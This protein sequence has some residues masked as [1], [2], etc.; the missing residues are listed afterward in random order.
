MP[1]RPEE[2]VHLVG[3]IPDARAQ[4]PA[5]HPADVAGRPGEGLLQAD[6]H[7]VP[8]LVVDR[9]RR[10]SFRRAGSGLLRGGL[11][12]SGG[13]LLCSSNGLLR[14]LRGPPD[15][16]P[17]AHPS[18]HLVDRFGILPVVLDGLCVSPAVD[19]PQQLRRHIVGVA[20]AI[21][22]VNE[23]DVVRVVAGTLAHDT[24]GCPH[25]RDVLG[26]SAAGDVDVAEVASLQDGDRRRAP[27]SGCNGL[28]GRRG[29]GNSGNSLC[30]GPRMEPGDLS[31]GRGVS[32]I[33]A[34]D[35]D[36]V[37]VFE[38]KLINSVKRGDLPA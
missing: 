24:A 17:G 15:L 23:V 35:F 36:D 37:L 5:G 9:L 13:G 25:V 34:R 10:V 28:R 11:L 33:A 20:Q 12:C 14:L 38:A 22:G 27:R 3:A 6:L 30:G 26:V 32:H 1:W 29:G 7:E 18:C 4:K 2:E 19:L 16:L 21:G 31:P 8:D